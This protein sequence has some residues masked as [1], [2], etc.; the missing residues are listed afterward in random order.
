[1]LDPAEIAD[2]IAYL[3]DQT[4]FTGSCIHINGGKV[5]I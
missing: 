2:L 1:V 3:S 4:A 5:M